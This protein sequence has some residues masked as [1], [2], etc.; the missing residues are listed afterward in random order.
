MVRKLIKSLLEPKAYPEA[1]TKVR[2]VETHV[3]FIFLT[4]RFVYKVKKPVDYGFLDFTTLDRRRFYCE[5]ELRLNRRL[6]PGIYLGV[7]ELRETRGGASFAGD[8]KVIDY[9]VKMK[10]LPEERMLASLLRQNE[11]GPAEIAAIARVIADFHAK[12]ARGPQIDA[13]GST[14]IIRGN[15]EENFRQAAPFVGVTLSASEL[16]AIRRW[17]ERFLEEKGDLLRARVAG[18][19]V[20]ECDGDLHCG[21]ICLDDGVCIFDCIEFNDR[22]RFIDTAADLAFLLMDLEYAGRPDLS[23]LLLQEYLAATGDREM[24]GVLRFYKVYRAFVRGKVK[25][26]R[27]NEA[28]IPA[29]EAAEAKG[30]AARY[31]RLARG[32]TLTEGLAPPLVIT[33]GLMGSG[34]STLARQLSFELALLLRRSDAVRKTIAHASPSQAG[35]SYRGGIYTEELDRATYQALLT[36]ARSALSGGIGMVVDATFRRRGDRDDFRALARELGA[37]FFVIET[38]APERLIRERLEARRHDPEEV[39]D[40]RW[41][42][43]R[44]QRSEFEP[45]AE[46]EAITVDSSLPVT[47]G[48]DLALR[49]M[50]LP[51]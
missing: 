17:A 4:D 21:N 41:E 42:H 6:C 19:F 3:S 31:F 32:Y 25:S 13:C 18:G 46:G 24:E 10:R 9:A 35:V 39:S 34:K 5:E 12:A 16:A 47:G 30:A 43:F 8:G 20:R 48:V 15:W 37:P 38:R 7:V 50:G 51:A 22:F 23:A 49:G 33:C 11:A 14:L 2:L 36:E 1:T 44:Q 28:G 26:F 45:P 29:Q 27:V 40:G